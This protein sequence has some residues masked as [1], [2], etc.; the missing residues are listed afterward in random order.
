[1][2]RYILDFAKVSYL[3]YEYSKKLLPSEI[4]FII[5][6]SERLVGAGISKSI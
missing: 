1:V 2:E 4:A 5:G 6:I 3:S